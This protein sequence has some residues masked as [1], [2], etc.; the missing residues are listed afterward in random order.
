MPTRRIV[1]KSPKKRSAAPK[2][3]ASS[4]RNAAPKRR[5]SS[6][7]TSHSYTVLVGNIGTVYDGKSKASADADYRHYVA[8]SKSGS[9]R[10]GGESVTMFEDGRIIREFEGQPSDDY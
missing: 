10:A 3:R 9:G 6:P 8:E 1:R 2:K 5:P 4:K 7:R